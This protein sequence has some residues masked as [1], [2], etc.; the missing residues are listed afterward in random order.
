MK[1]DLEMY[2]IREHFFIYQI[3]PSAVLPNLL[4]LTIYLTRLHNNCFYFG[5]DQY[6]KFNWQITTFVSYSRT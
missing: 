6:Y 4:R 3:K 1:M 5:Y 2:V